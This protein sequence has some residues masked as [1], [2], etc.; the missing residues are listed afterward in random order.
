MPF[1]VFL[2]LYLE[3]LKI[4]IS[5]VYYLSI[6][7]QQITPSLAVK[8]TV[9]TSQFLGQKDREELIWV[10]LTQNVSLSGRQACWHQAGLPGKPGLDRRPTCKPAHV[11]VAKCL[12]TKA[13]SQGCLMT[14]EQGSLGQEIQRAPKMKAQSFVT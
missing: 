2:Y 12:S 6:A 7:M 8:T 11:V 3:T 4:D 13:S 1:C 10:F 14:W 5:Y 9:I